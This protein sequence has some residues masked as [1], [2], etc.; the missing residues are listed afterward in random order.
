M[1]GA[2]AAMAVASLAAGLVSVTASMF[3]ERPP[4]RWCPVAEIFDPQSTM[5]LKD[6]QH[7]RRAR[8]DM[9]AKIVE[10]QSVCYSAIEFGDDDLLAHKQKQSESF[11]RLSCYDIVVDP[12]FA[13][14]FVC[15]FVAAGPGYGFVLSY[16][17][18][19]H[20]LFD[21]ALIDA[22]QMLCYA[23]FFG[24]VGRLALGV[25]I[26]MISSHGSSSSSN[27]DSSSSAN[28]GGSKLSNIF[29][30]LLQTVGLAL[31][32]VAIRTEC[33]WL[34][35]LAVFC[36]FVAFN[37]G[38][39]VAACLARDVFAPE[40][41]TLAFALTGVAVGVARALFSVVLA[42]CD[43]VSGKGAYDWYIGWSVVVSLAGAVGAYFIEASKCVNVDGGNNRVITD[44]A[45]V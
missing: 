18:M 16:P 28:I 43:G 12:A 13:L 29:I 6:A 15:V 10:Q 3:I 17:L 8:G 42:A 45:A 36:V 23:T 25:A 32:P 19:L 20:S 2:I 30:L 24:V 21:M 27:D 33:A 40:N 5:T 22:N 31:M 1:G 14:V 38:A 11:G 34:F 37:G 41:S 7:E 9:Q 26:D 4:E 39:V 44:L 35:H